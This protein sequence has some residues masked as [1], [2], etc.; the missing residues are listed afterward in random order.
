MRTL[1]F[2]TIGREPPRTRR[3]AIEASDRMSV[4]RTG[5]AGSVRA[6]HRVKGSNARGELYG[7]ILHERG[8]RAFTR[9][10]GD[11]RRGRLCSC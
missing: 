2:D 7:S 9:R 6:H 3:F 8:N 4:E 10:A 1:R 11:L 5:V